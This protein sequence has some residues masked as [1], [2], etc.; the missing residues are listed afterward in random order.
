MKLNYWKIH[1]MNLQQKGFDS[2]ENNLQM[3]FKPLYNT[4]YTIPIHQKTKAKVGGRFIKNPILRIYALR[5]GNNT[6]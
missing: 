2:E 6:L 3:L 4:E 5:I 1:F